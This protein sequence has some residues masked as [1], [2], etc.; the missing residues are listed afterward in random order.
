MT[1]I[2][3]FNEF[4]FNHSH[5]YI[6][7]ATT[8]TIERETQRHTHNTITVEQNASN[9]PQVMGHQPRINHI[10]CDQTTE[11]NKEICCWE[12][13]INRK[14]NSARHKQKFD[15]IASAPIAQNCRYF[16]C[17]IYVTVCILF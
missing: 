16:F 11:Y 12:I 17:W 9:L 2:Y 15:V 7:L 13:V 14:T 1:N 10:T 4:H 3:S 6:M 5:M 8:I